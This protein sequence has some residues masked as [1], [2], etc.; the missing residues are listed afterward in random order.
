MGSS[1]AKCQYTV[2]VT[3]NNKPGETEIYRN[4]KFSEKLITSID[5]SKIKTIQDSYLA[6]FKQNGPREFLTTL[7]PKRTITYKQGLDL[8]TNLGSGI[9]KLDLA[10]RAEKEYKDYDLNLI[11]LMAQNREEWVILDIA[12][13]LYKFVMVP[14]YETLGINNLEF[15][16]EQTKIT[17]LF[18]SKKS[19][20]TLINIKNF[21]NLKNIV[22]LDVIDQEISE[23][24]EKI[25]L[26]VIK[27]KEII[28]KGRISKK[29]YV[30]VS[31][32]DIFTFSYTSGTTGNAKAV[33]CTHANFVSLQ[34]C[35]HNSDIKLYP[36]DYHLS[37]LPLAHL[38][39][40]AI[41]SY[42]ITVGVNIS[43]FR[44]DI[45]KIKDDI[46]LVRPTTFMS[47]PRLYN[48]FYNGI[49]AKFNLATG[50]KKTLIDNGVNKKIENLRLN[51]S[52]EDFIYDKLVFNKVKEMVGGRV[53]FMVTG[54][55]P[56]DRDVIDFLKICFCCPIIEGYGQTETTAASFLTSKNDPFSRKVGGPTPNT[57]FKL[58]DSNFIYSIYY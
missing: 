20:N 34:G 49:K 42:C 46:A 24:L 28:D 6:S 2:K 16:L 50:W 13:S 52:Y 18:I 58:I 1:Q 22:L 41:I 40:R 17:T 30:D 27:Y 5:E 53:R 12:N 51:S 39:E 29:D 36:S 7:E 11:G 43:F 8:A 57:E 56:I 54:S 15:I 48:K 19:L 31:P 4:K 26:K 9:I 47:V 38:Y 14:L 55:A 23:K 33:M 37:Y 44:G 45:L 25:N 35:L 32:N 10:Y 21:H 3:S